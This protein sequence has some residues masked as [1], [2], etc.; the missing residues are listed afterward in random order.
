[1]TACRS[2]DRRWADSDDAHNRRYGAL[3]HA[4]DW[5]RRE[6]QINH[7][8]AAKSGAGVFP[9]VRHVRATFAASRANA[10]PAPRR[11]TSSG[12]RRTDCPA[13]RRVS[14]K[15][16]AL[17]DWQG[18]T[19]LMTDNSLQAWAPR[20]PASETGPGRFSSLRRRRLLAGQ[21]GGHLRVGRLVRGMLLPLGSSRTPMSSNATTPCQRVDPFAQ[22]P[23]QLGELL[24]DRPVT[25]FRPHCQM[26]R[27]H[28]GAGRWPRCRPT[29]PD[30][31]T[32]VWPSMDI[33]YH[34]TN[35]ETCDRCILI[36]GRPT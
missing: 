32:V 12:R 13:P 34:R 21:E 18:H 24:I 19:G 26:I 9:S 35:H 6:T 11:L 22:H 4:L 16:R 2:R 36:T 29:P 7:I 1:M 28:R 3:R 17:V 27:G 30:S 15:R 5:D 23:A 10:S 14:W 8:G 33:G 31:Q 25:H 20:H